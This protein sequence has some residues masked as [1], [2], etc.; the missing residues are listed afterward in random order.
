VDRASNAAG[1]LERCDAALRAAKAEQ[2]AAR[3]A[4]FWATGK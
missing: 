4:R 2:A 3:M 1:E